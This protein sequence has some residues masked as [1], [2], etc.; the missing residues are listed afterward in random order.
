LLRR[1]IA[2]DNAAMDDEPKR[3]HHPFQF[4]LRTLL[5]IVT[6][7]AAQCAICLPPLRKWQAEREREQAL[8]DEIDRAPVPPSRPLFSPGAQPSTRFVR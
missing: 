3:K 8:W 4:R 7:V 2:T 6:I 5:L 1:Q